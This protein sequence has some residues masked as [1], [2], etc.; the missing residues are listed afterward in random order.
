M[1]NIKTTSKVL[2]LDRIMYS[3]NALYHPL[4]QVPFN[5]IPLKLLPSISKSYKHAEFW[6]PFLSVEFLT[7]P[8]QVYITCICYLI[9][10][11]N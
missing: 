3:K 9:M 2:K 1:I 11:F 5:Q 8:K 4:N 6:R 7:V 10:Y